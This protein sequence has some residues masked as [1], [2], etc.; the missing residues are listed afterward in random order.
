MVI[1]HGRNV[2][3]VRSLFVSDV[4]LGCR[5]AQAEAFLDFINRYEPDYLYLVGD[6][7]DGWKLRK[8]WRWEESY[9]Q[10]L[11]RL[12]E[13]SRGGTH[14]R[15]AAG[16]H[17]DFLRGF[18]Q[19]FGIFE[20]ADE[21]V[22]VA[23]DNRRFLVIHGD[24]F[25]GVECKAKWLS[26]GSSFLY[27]TLLSLNWAINRLRGNRNAPYAFCG[28]IK[29]QI[30]GLVKFFSNFE[31]T[32]AAAA[33]EHDCQGVICGHIHAPKIKQIDELAYC[34]TGDWVENCTALVEY[35]DGAMEI[36]RFH[37]G[38]GERLEPMERPKSKLPKRKIA[39]HQDLSAEA[40]SLVG[41]T[42][43]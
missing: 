13:L 29:R 43:D 37:G 11:H 25:D 42:T 27:D 1:I 17:D 30:K 2:R 20:L 33:D 10:I 28:T 14:I 15:Y 7:I 18:L 26:V 22:H 6:F 8:R 35:D 16:N 19:H 24:R 31:Q 12:C 23:A 36:I 38:Q 34:N 32:L 21:F 39:S 3:S 41:L 9:S 4:H 5:H 40:E